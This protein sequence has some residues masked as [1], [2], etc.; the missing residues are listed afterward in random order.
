MDRQELLM[1]EHS[2]Q[3]MIDLFK[4]MGGEQKCG[5]RTTKPNR[6]DKLNENGV[7]RFGSDAETSSHLIKG[8]AHD[9]RT[10]IFVTPSI[11]QDP[12]EQPPPPL[13]IT[14]IRR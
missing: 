1:W 13:T 5:E 4:A 8:Q 12:T 3:V 6:T 11:F 14:K 7:C 10:S 9:A 2:K